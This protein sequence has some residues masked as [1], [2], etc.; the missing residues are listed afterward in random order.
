MGK[1]I[2][3]PYIIA[4]VIGLLVLA[5]IF[6]WIYKMFS[7]GG[8]DCRNCRA[9][10]IQWCNLCATANANSEEWRKP[11]TTM[12]LDLIE[13]ADKCNLH[14]KSQVCIFGVV[15]WC[16]MSSFVLCQNVNPCITCQLKKLKES[17]MALGVE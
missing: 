7:G 14:P 10:F 4:L 11:V 17:C 15:D 2:A 8:M 13:C 5:F 6:Y 3:I 12:P 1:G 9:R 16:D